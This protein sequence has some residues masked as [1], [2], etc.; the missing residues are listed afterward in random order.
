MIAAG[1]QPNFLPWLGFFD[2]MQ[3]ADVFVIEDIVQ[4]ERSEFQN[5]NRIKTQ[6][7]PIWLTVPVEHQG[8]RQRIDNVK[9]A[10]RNRCYLL[11]ELWETLKANYANAPFWRNY[12]G[13]FEQAFQQHWTSL[14]DLNLHLIEGLRTF[15]GVYTPLVKAS[16]LGAFGKS[17][18]MIIAQ[19]KELGADVYLSG[20]GAKNY[21]NVTRFRQEGLEVRFQD[22]Q[23]PIYPQLYGEFIPNLSAVDYLFCVGEKLSSSCASRNAAE[24]LRC[25]Q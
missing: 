6:T 14:S 3:K 22:F 10:E 21:L 8:K 9:I 2:K 19:C 24:Q 1:H 25:V 23:H 17:S 11:K 16:K 4:F 13:F 12:S 20:V 18:E 5:R 15:L 7:G